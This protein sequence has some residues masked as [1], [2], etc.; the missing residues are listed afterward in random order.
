MHDRGTA[1]S[2]RADV[3]I[4]G[5]GATPAFSRGTTPLLAGAMAATAGYLAA[6]WA[7]AGPGAISSSFDGRGPPASPAEAVVMGPHARG[8]RSRRLPPTPMI[9]RVIAGSRAGQGACTNY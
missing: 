2:E 3:V 8:V 7:L 6:R 1:D 9:A 4:T 5:L